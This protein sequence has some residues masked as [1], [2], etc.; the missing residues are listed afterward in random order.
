MSPPGARR[1]VPTRDEPER[2]EPARVVTPRPEP[3]A[4]EPPEPPPASRVHAYGPVTP[5]PELDAWDVDDPWGG[6]DPWRASGLG[7]GRTEEADDVTVRQRD[8]AVLAAH[9]RG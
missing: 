2:D 3:Q 9:G 1:A 6:L 4:D 7:V 8:L 5:V